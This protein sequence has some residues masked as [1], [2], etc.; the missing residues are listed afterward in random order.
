M[1]KE[2]P[3][4]YWILI[5]PKENEKLSSV[6]ETVESKPDY[7]TAKVLAVGTEDDFDV[8]VGD[9]VIYTGTPHQITANGEKHLIK[10][11]QIMYAL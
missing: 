6:I 4:G 7:R 8:E 9:T 2:R 5:E 11:H 3:I 10:Q 1:Q